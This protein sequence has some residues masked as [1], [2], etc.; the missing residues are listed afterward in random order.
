MNARRA[1]WILLIGV[2]TFCLLMAE[3]AVRIVQEESFWLDP[4][5]DE[6]WFLALRHHARTG[7]LEEE[8]RDVVYDPILGWRMRPNLDQ[9]RYHTNALG[10]RGT[11]DYPVERV[12]GKKRV[13]LLGDSYTYGLGVDD[14]D[15][16]GAILE[17]SRDDLEV[18]RC[19]SNSWGTDQA[20]LEY[21]EYK[22]KFQPDVIVFGVYED[23]FMR[24]G[25]RAREYLKPFFVTEGDELRL[26]AV[27]VPPIEEFEESM[28]P[29]TSRPRIVDAV[30]YGY[31]L[32]R[33]RLT[34]NHMFDDDFERVSKVNRLILRELKKE[35]ATQPNQPKLVVMTWPSMH[36]DKG[37]DSQRIRDDIVASAEAEGLPV[38]DLEGQLLEKEKELGASVYDPAVS[39]WNR[40]GHEVA[41]R[42]LAEHFEKIDF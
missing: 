37:W 42:Q 12:P 41:A 23:D 16:Y 24:T 1:T 13:M 21:R 34:G 4:A 35:A 3:V 5:D 40:A 18:L 32:L 29:V 38:Y 6:V 10:M 28:A 36:Y 14:D 8:G 9:G 22:K 7:K 39:H 25:V 19:A 2:T 26:T 11:T 31:Q 33:F 27:P 15:T 20:F 17:A 30:R